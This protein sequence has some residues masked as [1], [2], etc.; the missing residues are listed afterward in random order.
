VA[1]GAVVLRHPVNL[2]QG[3]ALQTGIDYSLAH[4]ADV[5]VTF[6]GDGQ[7]QAEDVAVL[8]ERLNA[9]GVDVVL[10]SRFLGQAVGL[11]KPR[12]AIIKV[13]TFLTRITT[14]LRLTDVHNGLRA[15][16]RRA[17]AT[18]QI[19]QNRMAHASEILSTIAREKLTHIE[20][21]VTVL[22]TPYSK[23]KGQRLSD[24]FAILKDLLVERMQ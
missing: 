1:E 3:A 16:T 14:G 22:Y 9:S 2:G 23:E 6:D 8:V 5:V 13:A 17:A 21:P 7:H 19:R 15:F 20:V 18:I 10:G 12:R 24:V 11:T 4:D